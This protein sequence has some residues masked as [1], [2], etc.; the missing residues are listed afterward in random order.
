MTRHPSILVVE[1]DPLYRTLYHARVAQLIPDAQIHCAADG[2]E[3]L[4]ILSYS[5]P[6]LV[7]LDLH[8][9]QIDGNRLL[10]LIK[11]NSHNDS[12][13]VFVI[14]AFDDELT[15]VGRSGYTNVFGFNK[16]MRADEFEIVLRECMALTTDR[17][18]K[19]LHKADPLVDRSHMRLYISGDPKVQRE[20]AG[21]FL[22]DAKDWIGKMHQHLQAGDHAALAECARNI[23]A[24]ASTVGA[25]DAAKLAHRLGFAAKPDT[26]DLA[27]N[28]CDQLRIALDAYCAALAATFDPLPARRT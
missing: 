12:M 24:A 18:P 21:H 11:C 14:S 3:A 28:L 5:S 6:D 27:A 15:Q 9:P 20:V 13:V 17:T 10:K 26:S 22:D 7:I 1:D 23:W 16:P 8:I 2:E 25:H 19:L 4:D